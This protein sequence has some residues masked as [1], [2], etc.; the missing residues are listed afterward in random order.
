MSSEEI[1]KYFDATESREIRDDLVF[2]ANM[3][4]EPKIAIDCGCGAGADIEYLATNGFKVYGFDIEK[5]SIARCRSRFKDIDNV[6]LSVSSFADFNYPQASLVVADASLFFCPS[7][8]FELVWSNIY[9][10]LLPNGIFCGSF[11][12]CEDTMAEQGENTSVFWPEAKA[13]EENEVKA[14]FK[15][16]EVLRFNTHKSTGKTSQGVAHNWHIFQVVAQKPNKLRLA[17]AS[18]RSSDVRY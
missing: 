3:I 12:G 7:S 14:L 2:S 13:F 17:D 8:E 9:Q 5:D 4:S 16:F 11:L 10:C 18:H 6:L 1:A 15:N